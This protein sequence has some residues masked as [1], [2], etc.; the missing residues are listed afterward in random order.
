[1]NKSLATLLKAP[2]DHDS[3]AQVTESTAPAE[4]LIFLVGPKAQSLRAAQ[5][6]PM[7]AAFSK[8]GARMAD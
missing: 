2:K 4:D 6:A 1:M 3:P 8:A 5:A 7:K